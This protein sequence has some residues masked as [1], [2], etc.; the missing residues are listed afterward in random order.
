MK[1]FKLQLYFTF[2]EISPISSLSNNKTKDLN[3]NFHPIGTKTRSNYLINC[4][5]RELKETVVNPPLP[6]QENDEMMRIK[7]Y[8]WMDVN[9]IVRGASLQKRFRTKATSVSWLRGG[10]EQN[11]LPEWLID[12]PLMRRSTVLIIFFLSF[13]SLET[14]EG[15][16]SDQISND[17]DR[18]WNPVRHP[19]NLIIFSRDIYH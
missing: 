15:I 19:C 18:S 1:I 13:L 4:E 5:R 12:R 10:N 17:H 8:A 14:A 7:S 9:Y 3:V 2:I 16:I 11:E 6:W